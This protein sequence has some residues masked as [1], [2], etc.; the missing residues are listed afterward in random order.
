MIFVVVV[1][2]VVGD[3]ATGATPPT[4]VPIGPTNLRG[5]RI[6]AGWDGREGGR[7][8]RRR[9]GRIPVV[10]RIGR[11]ET[12]VPVVGVPVGA[13]IIVVSVVIEV[14]GAAT[15]AEVV[16]GIRPVTRLGVLPV[17]TPGIVVVGA[18]RFELGG[19][20]GG[21]LAKGIVHHS[22]A[23]SGHVRFAAVLE[24]H[25][26]SP[27]GKIR[28]VHG[29]NPS[30]RVEAIGPAGASGTTTARWV[31]VVV[32]VVGIASAAA[33]VV[34]VVVTVAV[35]VVVIVGRAAVV[36][37]IVV[38]VVSIVSVPGT[39]VLHVIRHR[40]G[41]GDPGTAGGGPP[42]LSSP[43][44]EGSLAKGIGVL[45]TVQQEAA[46]RPP[47]SSRRKGRRRRR[48]QCHETAPR[49][50]KGGGFVTGVSVGVV[51]VV[52]AVI[53]AILRRLDGPQG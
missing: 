51:L 32:V 39:T 8:R 42:D 7:R 49:S 27:S 31:S 5:G 11:T 12:V 48:R 36:V 10:R 16:V 20:I 22:P 45:G 34:I 14:A 53:V 35:V 28:T 52:A 21:K 47:D 6:V 17:A 2:I 29:T 24:L 50:G 15:T 38:V 40:Q 19:G 43:V 26:P 4:V 30:D 23:P 33:V 37:A 46:V 1:S 41:G 44:D 9:N 13:V 3:V 25:G 18:P